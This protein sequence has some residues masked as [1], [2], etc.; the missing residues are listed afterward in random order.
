MKT[1]FTLNLNLYSSDTS[2]I[3]TTL[4][5]M[6]N[7]SGAPYAETW[8][9]KLTDISIANSK[10]MFDKF[11]QNVESTFYP[12]NSKAT[13]HT[14][15]RS[16]FLTIPFYSSLILVVYSLGEVDVIP[17]SIPLIFSFKPYLPFVSL[18]FLW[19]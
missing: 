14:V 13:V 11:V 3:M 15:L 5:K 18:I 2:K 9:D 17:T 16:F 8:D 10:K 7:G 12:F 1:Y 19:T 4:N 6:S